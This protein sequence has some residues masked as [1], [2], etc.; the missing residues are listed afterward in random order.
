MSTAE[1]T[2]SMFNALNKA[3]QLDVQRYIR[4]IF[5]AKKRK[6]SYDLKP[7]TERQL[8][9]KINSSITQAER[10]EV[11]SLTEIKKEVAKEYG[12]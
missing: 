10:G 6:S 11:H 9:K 4:K 2:I 3:E 7:L 5:A 8:I 12:F 1:Q